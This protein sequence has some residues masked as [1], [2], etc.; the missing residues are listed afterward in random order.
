MDL[1]KLNIHL[2][3]EK[4]TDGEIEELINSLSAEELVELHYSWEF[5]ARENQ[6]PPAWK[7][8]GWLILAG[9]GFGKALSNSV[10][11]RTLDAWKMMGDLEIGD[12]I[13]DEMGFPTRVVGV[14]PQGLKQVYRV[15]FSDKTWIDGCKDHLW[16][17]YTHNERKQLLRH[18]KHF[19]LADWGNKQCISTQDILSTIS[20]GSR[21][22]N[23]HCIPVAHCL[24]TPSSKLEVDP[25]IA[26]LWIGN[27]HRRSGEFSCHKND[28]ITYTQAL[29]QCNYEIGQDRLEKSD[30]NAWRISALGLFSDLMYDGFKDKFIPK[31][32]LNG[33]ITQRLGFLRGLMDSD[34]TVKNSIV[35]F[36]SVRKD[37]ADAAMILARSLGQKP[38]LYTGTAKLNGVITGPNYRVNWRPC[39]FVQP[40]NMKR[41][42]E[43]VKF[44]TAQE[45]RNNHRMVVGVEIRDQ[46]EEMT[47]IKVDSSN[48]LFL[49][50]EA[51]IPTHNTRAGSEWII[52]RAREGKGPIALIGETT[53]DVRDTM[54]EV[55]ESSIMRICPPDF[56][57]EYE[58]SKRRLTFPNGIIATTFTGQEPGQLRGPQHQSIWA[59]EPAKWDYAED[60][61]E[62]F[63]YGLRIGKNPQFLATT[64]PRPI[65]IIKDWYHDKSVAVTEGSTFDNAANLAPAFIR[66]MKQKYEGTRM[67]EQ[68]LA[69][70]ILWE[71][72]NALWRQTEI[73]RFRKSEDRV[74]EFVATA[75]AVDP[76][77]GDPNAGRVKVKRPIDECGLML[78]GRGVEGHGYLTGDFTMRGTP[79]AWARKVKAILDVYNP[80][81]IVAEKNQG[82]LMV[83]ETLRAYGIPEARIILVNA[84]QGKLVRAEPISLM[85]EQGK[86]H[87][88]G[89]YL[90]LESELVTYEGKGKSPNRLDALVWLFYH[91]LMKD[92][93]RTIVK[94]NFYKKTR[95]VR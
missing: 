59:D 65:K 31:K 15:H 52:R 45:S 27:G 81:F 56:M 58:P 85:A 55:G 46:V 11:I 22:D 49:A 23:N 25:Y 79:Q 40:F 20:T 87:H 33:S 2:L 50:G 26:G 93:R 77:I 89:E 16:V 86:I 60:C 80:D 24:S 19:P 88:V 13:F 21:G 36:T 76:T 64:T 9:R 38:R 74:P 42:K 4:M 37:H 43:Q 54:I 7:W 94:G 66:Q 84:S 8:F 92:E 28:R 73:D 69:G 17:T 83:T 82:G 71:S 53:A 41:K 32:Y 95:R 91:L 3:R 14:Y 39:R 75:L 68:E 63:M 62:Q 47:C 72:E 1:N 57:P 44:D 51:L 18:N 67:G 5:W 12:M 29:A 30:S 90:E 70:K 34:G 48:S 61:V 6:L 10:K 35:E 78:G